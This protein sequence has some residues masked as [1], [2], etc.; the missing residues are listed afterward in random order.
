MI[1]PGKGS[2]FFSDPAESACPAL[3]RKMPAHSGSGSWYKKGGGE[4]VEGIRGKGEKGRRD[5]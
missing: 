2:H 3:A 1:Y 5:S 4:M